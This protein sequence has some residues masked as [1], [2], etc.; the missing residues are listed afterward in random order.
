MSPLMKYILCSLLV[1]FALTAFSQEETKTDSLTLLFLTRHAEKNMTESNNDPGLDEI[2]TQ[3]AQQL[4]AYLKDAGIQAVYATNTKRAHLTGKPL[5]DSLKIPVTTYGNDV[6]KETKQF[7]TKHRGQRVL[8]VGHS[9]TIPAM[10]NLFAGKEQYHP[11]EAYGLLYLVILSGTEL[12]T[13][14][15]LRY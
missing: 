14:V 11:D 6:E 10:L 12:R 1:S 7:V 8:I 2:G 5:A 3:R 15:T 4:A 13:I 9:N